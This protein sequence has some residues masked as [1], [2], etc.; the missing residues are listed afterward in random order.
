MTEV[1]SSRGYHSPRRAEQAAATRA[2][3][4]AAAARLFAEHGYAA[5]TM[6]AIAAEARVTPKS[7][8]S[9]AEKP[10]LLLLAVDREIVGDD[11]PVPVA[12]RPQVRALV[13]AEDPAEG[14]AEAARFGAETLLRLYPIYRAFEQAV[15]AEPALR[16]PWRDYQQRR[17]SDMRQ[18]VVALHKAGRLRPGLSVERATDSVW[19]LITWHTVALL[20]EEGGWGREEFAPW[21]EDLL[22]TLLAAQGA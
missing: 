1:N 8:Y 11:Q 9:L 21:L 18:L 20:A 16:T 7:V 2:A 10:Q 6:A 17:R 22:T 5:T 3:I 19:A 15:A 4:I 12:D 14:F 13:D